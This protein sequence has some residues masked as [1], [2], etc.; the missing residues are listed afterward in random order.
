MPHGG[1]CFVLQPRVS[2]D[3]KLLAPKNVTVQLQIMVDLSGNES[4]SRG[5]SSGTPRSQQR[6]G[7]K[8]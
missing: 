5:Q 1:K 8:G 7:F 6:H 2:S 4:D 3:G